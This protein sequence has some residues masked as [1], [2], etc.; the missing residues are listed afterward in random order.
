MYLRWLNITIRDTYWVLPHHLA[1]ENK[2]T[3]HSSHSI[4]VVEG[5]LN[6]CLNVENGRCNLSWKH[7]D[8]KVL[9]EILYEMTEDNKYK[10]EEWIFD[11]GKKLLWE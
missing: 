3:M 5:Y 10:E 1:L 6:K 9:M 8:C 11:P 7:D 2:K 4:N